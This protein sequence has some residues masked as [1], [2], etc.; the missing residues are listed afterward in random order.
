MAEHKNLL[1][2]Y[3]YF[4]YCMGH[5]INHGGFNK[6][7]HK[8]YKMHQAGLRTPYDSI[9][10]EAVLYMYYSPVGSL[11]PLC[12]VVRERYVYMDDLEQL[13]A[14][15]THNLTFPTQQRIS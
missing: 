1:V 7:V 11:R 15:P 5:H 12:N 13:Q 3:M 14:P 6:N 10:I 8:Y 9:C 4:S 2:L